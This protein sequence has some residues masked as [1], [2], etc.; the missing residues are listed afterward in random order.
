MGE[1][2]NLKRYGYGGGLI[3]GGNFGGAGHAL[4]GEP[5]T[6]GEI[7][8]DRLRGW[9][10]RL[11]VAHGQPDAGGRGGQQTFARG[12]LLHRSDHR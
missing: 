9:L 3:K 1:R 8:R 4:D 10:L 6:F 11:R 7:K 2:I 5:Q 12:R